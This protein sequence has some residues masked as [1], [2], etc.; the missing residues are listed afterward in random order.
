M[1]PAFLLSP[2]GR[3]LAL[4]GGIVTV[5]GGL[6]TAV[7]LRGHAAGKQAGTMAQFEYDRR[8]MLA[9]RALFRR[10]LADAEERERQATE[11]IRHYQSVAEDA[12]RALAA[13][14]AQRSAAAAKT[15]S[16]PD[17]AVL[18][19]L[20]TKLGLREKND[21][22]PQLYARELRALDSAVTDY[23]LLKREN[24]LLQDRTLALEGTAQGFEQQALAIAGQ[25]DAW[26]TWAN[27]VEI[28]YVRVYNALPKKGNRFLRIITF[29]LAGKARRLTFPSPDELAATRPG[30]GK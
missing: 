2:L 28:H 29:G 17:S 19:D 18:P 24:E 27:Q 23:P 25:R 6:F 10:Q 11:Q 4:L 15:A 9:E 22:S 8:Q 20:T 30:G 5:V 16:L 21:L 26:I 3:K 1:I 7:Y 12:R 14:K 13:V